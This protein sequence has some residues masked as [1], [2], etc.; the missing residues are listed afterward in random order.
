MNGH[1]PKHQDSS[2][3]QTEVSPSDSLAVHHMAAMSA[4]RLLVLVPPEF[5]DGAATRRIWELAR[6]T[7]RSVKLLSLCKD[8]V[9]EASLRRQLVMMSALVGH[10]GIAIEAK[11]EIGANWVEALKR[12]Y[13]TGDIIVCFA[14]QR[15]GFLNRPLNQI[16]EEDLDMPIVILSGLYPQYRS[17]LNLLSRISL[18]TGLIS[19]ITGAFFLQ[20]QITA[21][22]RGWEQTTLLIF[23]VI[24]EF[25]LIWGWNHLFS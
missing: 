19:I 15:V 21:L 22:L 20:I 14:E 11:V 7:G 6:A 24:A 12:N 1:N 2:L 16:L 17:R 10:G 18:W 3:A 8:R 13:Q 23:S 25:S 9:K 5:D 4:G